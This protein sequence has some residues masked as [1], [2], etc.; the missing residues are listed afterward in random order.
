MGY[1]DGIPGENVKVKK[2]NL[3]CI[4]YVNMTMNK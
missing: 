3:L 1:F 2:L 4:E